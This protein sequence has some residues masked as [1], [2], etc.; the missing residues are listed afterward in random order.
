MSPGIPSCASITMRRP[1]A[2]VRSARR[3]PGRK[4]RRAN[5][6]SGHK[7]TTRPF[8][9][10]ATGRKPP[11]SKP[12]T[13]RQAGIEGTHTQAIRRCG[14]RQFRYIGQ[15]K[16]HVQHV[17]T[18]TAVNPVRVAAWLEGPCSPWPAHVPR[19]RQR[20]GISVVRLHPPVSLV[21]SL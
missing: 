4:T 9:L 3:T 20:S 1:V 16:T 6:P 7:S 2:P 18:A 14:L 10:R 21:A 13:P 19:R 17:L 12:N 11:S 5:S 15:A 8:K